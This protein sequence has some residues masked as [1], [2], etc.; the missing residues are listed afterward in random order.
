MEAQFGA[1]YARSIAA[2]YRL[3]QLGRT[4]NEALEHGD[5]AKAVWKAVCAE[6]EVPSQLR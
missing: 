3:P 1:G 6:F 2:D 5:E 4:V